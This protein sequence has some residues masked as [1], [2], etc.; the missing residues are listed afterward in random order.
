VKF[1]TEEFIRTKYMP[2]FIIVI[3]AIGRMTMTQKQK[4]RNNINH[5]WKA[6]YVSPKAA[7][8]QR[9]TRK[10]LDKRGIK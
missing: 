5:P 6:N 3:T 4:K 1:A 9:T 8:D 2:I 7:I 10:E